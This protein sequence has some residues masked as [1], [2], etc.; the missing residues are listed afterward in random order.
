MD[1]IIIG[2]AD[3]RKEI[4][5]DISEECR[6]VG[7]T[8]I[9]KYYRPFT[10]F[11]YVPYYKI[12]DIKSNTFDYVVISY[13]NRN[14]IQS[15]KEELKNA[16]LPTNGI[17][18]YQLFKETLCIDQLKAFS[19]SDQRF[20]I[21]LFGMSHSQCSIQPQYFAQ[22]LFKFAAP[23]MDLFCQ[24]KIVKVL[25][26]KYSEN[27][28]LVKKIVFELPYYIFNFDL[29][30]FRQ[31]V[32][33]RFYYFHLFSDYHHFGENK[34]DHEL[35]V[36]FEN[37]VKVFDRDNRSDKFTLNKDLDTDVSK[38]IISKAKRF[39]HEILR[40]KEICWFKDDVWFKNYEATKKENLELWNNILRQIRSA[41]PKAEIIVLVCPFDPL[42]RRLYKKQIEE[43]KKQFYSLIGDVEIVDNF[44]VNDE[45]RFA[46]HC[47]LKTESGIRYT[48]LIRKQLGDI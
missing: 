18:E 7:Y 8:D 38:D 14:D 2:L 12:E 5:S 6:I 21:L 47:H 16:G 23:S 24:E 31:F 40:L 36:H 25:V 11:D 39:A 32:L 34:T 46:D 13:K 41:N 30:R 20:D 22:R 9:K 48:Q 33:N 37:F 35:I 43:K 1:I 10:S 45:Y 44:S 28:S 19:N 29:S 17:I 27:I 4:L 3:N 15:A 26:T 42:F